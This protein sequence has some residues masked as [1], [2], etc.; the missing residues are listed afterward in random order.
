MIQFHP[1]RR[2]FA[3]ALFAAPLLCVAVQK[4]WKVGVLVGGTR[5][6]D[7]EN[8]VAALRDGMHAAGLREGRD[9]T[10]ELAWGGGDITMIRTA[11]E[12][13]AKAAFDLY[14]VS[15]ATAARE[16]L[17]LVSTRPIVFWGVSDPVGNGFVKN[18]ARPGGNVTGFELYPYEIGG[19]WLQLLKDAAPRATTAHVLMSANNPN[20]VGWRLSME[21]DAARMQ[22]KL[23]WPDLRTTNDLQAALT[24]AARS[25]GA[26]VIALA[27]PFLSRADHTSLLAA[28]ALMIPMI[29]GLPAGAERG[30]LISYEVDQV[31]LARRAGAY[32]AR[33]MRGE[34]AGDLPV[35]G[36]DTFKLVINRTVQR[37]LGIELPRSL[38]LQAHQVVD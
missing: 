25:T 4:V 26:G 33:V 6:R 8:A 38:L 7:T 9:F 19:K 1:S 10:I 16:L 20:I 17:K 22:L 18:A 28:H 36:A 32:L 13:M 24:V 30:A 2:T 3:A 15:T 34:K 11:A 37:A 21:R 23:I 5:Q 14:G 31:E 27:D 35:Q 29:T 12:T